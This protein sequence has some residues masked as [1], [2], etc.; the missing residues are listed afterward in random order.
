MSRLSV[1]TNNRFPF[2]SMAPAYQESASAK[3]W[4]FLKSG[5]EYLSRDP[6]HVH[7]SSHEL[8]GSLITHRQ[9]GQ[10]IGTPELGLKSSIVDPILV[11][12]PESKTRNLSSGVT[13]Q[14][15]IES[16]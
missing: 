1:A 8:A 14:F 6:V 4:S 16:E 2:G 10:D 5:S 9:S 12:R 7:A 15:P 11:M 13:M 3:L